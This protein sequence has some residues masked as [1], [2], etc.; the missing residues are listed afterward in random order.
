MGIYIIWYDVY[1][2]IL[3]H[4]YIYTFICNNPVRL[5]TRQSQ[6][7]QPSRKNP[8]NRL[9]SSSPVVANHVGHVIN[10]Q[11]GD[12]IYR[13]FIVSNIGD[14]LWHCLYHLSGGTCPTSLSRESQVTVSTPQGP[15]RHNW[16]RK[17]RPRNQHGTP[18]RHSFGWWWPNSLVS[19]A[20]PPLEAPFTSTRKM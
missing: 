3:I 5:G 1:I 6:L 20:A 12:E 19:A 7:L 15:K 13:P 16:P 17:N 11:F 18:K 2:Y 8:M 4:I 10:L 14:G 9:A